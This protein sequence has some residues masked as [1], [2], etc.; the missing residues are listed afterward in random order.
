[1]TIKGINEREFC[2]GRSA[3]LGSAGLVAR[4]DNDPQLNFLRIRLS[5]LMTEQVASKPFGN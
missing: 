1:M 4:G 3:I 2:Y 5:L